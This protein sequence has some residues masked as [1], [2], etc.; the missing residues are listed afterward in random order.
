[1]RRSSC[2]R[3]PFRFTIVVPESHNAVAF[4]FQP[5]RP[6]PVDFLGMLAT[7]EFDNE[8]QFVA[9]KVDDVMTERYL[10][11][12]LEIAELPVA[13][14]GPEQRFGIGGCLA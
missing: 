5:L 14:A 1:M 13:K 12:E 11:A 9:V 8:P 10:P 3:T 7:V 4:A 6:R 2:A